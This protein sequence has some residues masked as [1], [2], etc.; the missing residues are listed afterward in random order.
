[1]WLVFLFLIL[2]VLQILFLRVNIVLKNIVINKNSKDFKID[3]DFMLFGIIRIFCVHLNKYGVKFLNKKFKYENFIS[4]EK[5][6][7]LKLDIEKLDFKQ[8]LKVIKDMKIKISTAKFSLKLGLG[9]IFLTNIFVVIVSSL[10]SGL[11][12]IIGV[13]AN[14]KNIDYKI[15]PEFNKMNLEFKG[16]FILSFRFFELI[17]LVL[18]K[19]YEKKKRDSKSIQK[20]ISIEN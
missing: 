10:I 18:K 16:N 9:E 7:H 19:Y 1:M 3:I 12:A 4:K 13:K 17:K 8:P 14:L 5:I 6:E 20:S 2:I 11:C 15:L